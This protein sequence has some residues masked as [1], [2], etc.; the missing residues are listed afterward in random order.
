M[1]VNG[2]A[3][4]EANKHSS[5]SVSFATHQSRLEKELKRPPTF[6]EVFDKTYK[7]KGT[8]QYISDRAREVAQIT[9]KYAWEEEPQLD[10]GIWVTTFGALKKGHVYGFGHNLDT[11]RML[12]GT[13]S[14][15][16]QATSAFTTSGAS[17]SEMTGFIRDEISGL[18]SRLVHMMHTQVSNAV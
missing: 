7:K 4:P 16:S 1:K 17:P 13:S 2:A 9:E 14:S 11:S 12:S 3:N 5:G 10:P 18:E 8:N 15:D 6:Q